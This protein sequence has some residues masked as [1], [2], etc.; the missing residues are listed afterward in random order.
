MTGGFDPGRYTTAPLQT[1][2]VIRFTGSL[3]AVFA[4]IAN[5]GALTDW[6]PMLKTVQVSH[7]KSLPPG[8]SMIGTTR[9][10]ALRGGV[11]LREEIEAIAPIPSALAGPAVL[12]ASSEVDLRQS[13]TSPQEVRN[14]FTNDHRRLAAT[15]ACA[16]VSTGPPRVLHDQ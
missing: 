2:G 9:V 4:R 16:P 11:T 10:L 6:V 5:H 14:R 1:E 8:E 15:N 3:D 7:P 12:M 13:A